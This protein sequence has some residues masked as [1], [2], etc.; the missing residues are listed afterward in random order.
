MS[1]LHTAGVHAAVSSWPSQSSKILTKFPVSLE[2][3]YWNPRKRCLHGDTFRSTH[4]PSSLQ[5]VSW[6]DCTLLFISSTAF[7]SRFMWLI[8]FLAPTNDVK[9][10]FCGLITAYQPTSRPELYPLDMSP[11]I[12]HSYNFAWLYLIKADII[13]VLHQH[14]QPL[15]YESSPSEGNQHQTTVTEWSW[16]RNWKGNQILNSL[17][18]SCHQLEPNWMLVSSEW[19][20]SR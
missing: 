16:L 15:V 6:K 2:G 14:Q 1:L 18:P 4:T 8:V 13:S 19:L 9:S 12:N 7:D 10:C 5:Q 11:S 3:N 17:L 20:G